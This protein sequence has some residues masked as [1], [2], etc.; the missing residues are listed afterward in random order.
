MS[1]TTPRVLVYGASGYTGRLIC[2][3]LREYGIPFV[4]AGRSKETLQ[5]SME[6]NVPGIETAEYEIVEVAHS[7]DE[8]ASLLDGIDVVCNTVGPFSRLGP[9]MVQACLATGTHY[10]DTTGEQDWLIRCDEEWGAAFAEKG[11][12]LAPGIAQMYT[13]GEIAAQLALETPGMDTLDIAV[14]L[15]EWLAMGFELAFPKAQR[16]VR[17]SWIGSTLVVKPDSVG[18][19]IDGEKAEEIRADAIGMLDENV[20]AL[21]RL[22]TFA[23]RASAIAST[24]PTWRPFLHEPWAA[25]A[26]ANILTATS[27]LANTLAK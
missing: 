17:V 16:R 9:D 26:P 20:V 7:R 19:W 8:L 2:E 13:T 21:P 12:L 3:Y 25:I 22:R 4:A 10:L 15:A 1:S 5:T 18:V 11:L 23:G 27:L 14:F 6:G 24:M